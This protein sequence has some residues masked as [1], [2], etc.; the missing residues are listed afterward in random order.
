MLS[1]VQTVFSRQRVQVVTLSAVAVAFIVGVGVARFGSLGAFRSVMGGNSLHVYPRVHE[2]GPV[3]PRSEVTVDIGLKNVSGEDIEVIGSRSS[4]D[5]TAIN[6]PV[7]VH[8]GESRCVSV[9]VT[10]PD[11]GEF[12][13]FVRFFTSR[14]REQPLITIR[15]VVLGQAET[16]H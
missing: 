2:L 3:R 10:A 9:V 1:S 4:C 8:S 13:V 6:L 16:P 15:G 5:C 12:E 14:M 7:M 11:T